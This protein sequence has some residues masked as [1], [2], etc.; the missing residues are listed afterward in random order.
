MER[1]VRFC[2]GLSSQG[3]LAVVVAIQILAHLPLIDKPPMGQHVWRQ[4]MGLSAAYNYYS[5]DDDFW[6]PTQNV[7]ES[8]ADDGTAYFEL[9]LVYWLIGKSYGITGFNHVA[10]RVAALLTGILFLFSAWTLMKAMRHSEIFV[11]WYL[12]FLSFT[13]FFF[14]YSIS[15]LPNLPA[16]AFFLFGIG[17]LIEGYRRKVSAVR[18]VPGFLLVLL[19][20]LSKATYLFYCLLLAFLAFH[21]FFGVDGKRERIKIC[22]LNAIGALTILVPNLLVWL[23]A[24][25]MA[26][27]SEAR[28]AWT[29]LSPLTPPRS[30]DEVSATLGTAVP[31]WFGEMIVGA[32]AIPFFTGGVL[33]FFRRKEKLGAFR[34]GFWM[35]WGIAFLVFSA[36]FFTRYREHAY[37]LTSLIVVPPLFSA[38]CAIR[39]FASSSKPLKTGAVVLLALS[40][41]YAP[42]RVAH[43]WMETQ[44]VPE[45]LLEQ[46]DRF[47]ELIPSG[48]LVLVSGDASPLVYLYFLQRKGRNVPASTGEEELAAHVEKGFRF[49][50][51]DQPATGV[52]LA[53]V[54]VSQAEIGDFT[55]CRLKR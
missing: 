45:A 12:F 5:Q 1:A 28:G 42:A 2:R 52:E 33:L 34:K 23:Y 30:W 25:G 38:Y 48:D 46:A 35:G 39:V 24:K 40:V 41:A 26:E 15:L 32:V 37:Y 55:V 54:C 16:L 18:M 20:T 43:R 11:K 9:P 51:S 50:V 53:K 4:T 21:H 6:K 22:T 49:W 3:F 27:S 19:A 13:P 10:G 47:R 17:L 44:Q 36:M 7:V 8:L 31:T 29:E 14:Y